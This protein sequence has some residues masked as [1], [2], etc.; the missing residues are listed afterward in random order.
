MLKMDCNYII[1]LPN[2]KD[3]KILA[4]F[5]LLE[6][7]DELKA[8][9]ANTNEESYL[10]LVD[11]IEKLSNGVLSNTEITNIVLDNLNNLNNIIDEVNSKMEQSVDFK[12]FEKALYNYLL[13][14][15]T[16]S[17]FSNLNE[18]LNTP[19]SL[20]YFKDISSSGIL[21]QTNINAQHEKIRADILS[22]SGYNGVVLRDIDSFFKSIKRKNP[23]LYFSN[24]L[25]ANN[26]SLGINSSNI[27]NYTIYNDGNYASLFLGLFKRIASNLNSDS[28]KEEFGDENFFNTSLEEGAIKLSGFE[29]LL[30]S[31]DPRSKAKINK[32]IDLVVKYLDSGNSNLKDSIRELFVYLK[33]EIYLEESLQNT[34][35]QEKFLQ[36]EFDYEN[37]F[38]NQEDSNYLDIVK[39][40]LGKYYANQERITDNLYENLINK[41]KLREDLILLPLSENFK[42]YVL[43]TSIYKRD[44]GV[45]VTGLYKGLAGLETFK[46][47]FK[48]GDNIL[49]RSKEQARDPYIKGQ[50]VELNE[51]TFSMKDK[52]GFSPKMLKYILSKGDTIGSKRVI[53]GIYPDYVTTSGTN[54]SSPISYTSIESFKSKKLKDIV[55]FENTLNYKELNKYSQ[56][57]NPSLISEGDIIEDP[58]SDKG[59]LKIVLNVDD[60]KVWIYIN[61]ENGGFVKQIPK[62][63]IS[64]IWSYSFNELTRNEMIELRD[65]FLAKESR[66]STLSS[67]KDK[68]SAKSGDYFLIESNG[69]LQYGK[70]LDSNTGK[71]ILYDSTLNIVNY[72]DL[73]NLTFYTPRNITS[74]YAISIIRANSWKINILNKPSPTNVPVRYVVPK[75]TNLNK[76]FLLPNLYANIGQY[77]DTNVELKEDEI[78]I[79]DQIKLMIYE[80]GKDMEGNQLYAEKENINSNIYKRNL[81][82]LNRVYKFSDLDESVKRALNPLQKGVYFR[83]F[84]GSNIDQNLYRIIRTTDNSVIAHYNRLNNEGKLLTFEKE[85]SIDDLLKSKVSGDSYYPD[86]SIAALYTQYGNRN[87]KNMIEAIADE[88]SVDE[89]IRKNSINRLIDKMKDTFSELGINVKKGEEGFLDTQKAKIESN[90]DGTLSIV[91]NTKNGDYSDLVH[92]NL[93][94]YLTLLRYNSLEEYNNLLNT[95][96]NEDLDLDLSTKEEM[97]VEK[98]I[99]LNKGDN[100]FLFNNLKDF[101]FSLAGVVRK[102]INPEYR[103]DLNNIVNNPIGFLNTKMR[104][105]YN[106][107][108]KN[109]NSPF[110]NMGLLASEPF[111][112]KWIEENNI[113]LKCN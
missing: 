35:V 45:R 90:L 56:I 30:M 42:P 11:Y 74:T 67:F 59:L 10:G 20:K 22:N 75:G 108:E 107:D 9:L 92:E 91:L 102:Y 70:I 99:K 26:N 87:F 52:N 94:I 109:N 40:D 34:I 60:N 80:S 98:I 57:D 64:K 79:T 104:N 61:S 106:I 12:S 113:K 78:D 65:N 7:N 46:H 18:V 89:I 77:K 14:D 41:I 29:E 73:D 8:I 24:V 112:R 36:E 48:E 101:M 93:H 84:K 71:S 17:K 37:T 16:N 76:L 32:A 68:N 82:G 111:L 28:L 47:T 6:T 33:P 66:D 96:L 15:T 50:V 27:E 13:N 58:T 103:F 3:V 88:S 38:K 51:D 97:L 53:T 100:T 72:N 49:Y 86:K 31:K 44:N 5:G 55:N 21:G 43:V 62:A 63:D 83:V 105:F 69:S 4:N 81:D 23:S 2:G 19:I 1:K 25:L 110:Y 54:D 39:E 85:F 95:A